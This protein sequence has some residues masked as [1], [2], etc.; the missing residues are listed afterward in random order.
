M[1]FYHC[2]YRLLLRIDLLVF[3]SN[4]RGKISEIEYQLGTSSKQHQ[5]LESQLQAKLT[6]V[7]DETEKLH[8]LEKQTRGSGKPVAAVS[9]VFIFIFS[10][11][12]VTDESY[13]Y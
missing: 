11:L 9:L 12:H 5:M 13:P 1:S 8:L 7:A 4:I 10:E 3:Q 6:A 2:V